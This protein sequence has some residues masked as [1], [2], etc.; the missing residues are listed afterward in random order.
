MKCGMIAIIG[1][2]NVGKSTL[3]NRLIGQKIAIVGSKPQTT[4]TR[5]L[6]I[7]TR[8][9]VQ[10]LFLDTPG[11]H[12]GRSRLNRRMVQAALDALGEADVCLYLVDGAEPA[13]PSDAPILDRIREAGIPT[14][15]VVN[16]I[17]LFKKER[18]IP[19]LDRLSREAPFVEIVPVS[20]LTGE[21][22]ERLVEVIPPYLPEGSALFPEDQITDVPM[23][24]LA[25]E[26]IREKIL[27]KTRQEIPHV[28]AVV[29]DRYE[30]DPEKGLAKI[31]AT[32]YVERES[33]KGIVIGKQGT[34]LKAVG[35][36]ARLEIER[37]S[38]MH[39]YLEL[40]VKVMKGWRD[41]ERSLD[42]LRY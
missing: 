5:I 14:I 17:D 28:V 7:L 3:L 20:A 8:H 25:A 2:A 36:E 22:V 34:L 24:T 12:A 32:I 42:E 35:Q 37:A 6:G 15:A 21:N 16:K 1:R 11:I 13:P 4:R 39:V 38:G 18:M 41:D 26:L 29:L 27:E 10:M 31:H 19:L 40:W 23:R 33:Q 30:E 9:D